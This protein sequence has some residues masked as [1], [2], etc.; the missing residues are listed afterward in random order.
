MILL[1]LL[2]I[3]TKVLTIVIRE[4]FL[5]DLTGLLD[6]MEQLNQLVVFKII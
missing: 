3:K 5:K 1:V 4:F 2:E 6:K